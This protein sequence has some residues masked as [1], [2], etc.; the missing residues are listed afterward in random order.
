MPVKLRREITTI[1]DLG[2]FRVGSPVATARTIK[3]PADPE[4]Q[5]AEKIAACKAKDAV[6]RKRLDQFAIYKNMKKAPIF[7]IEKQI[8]ELN[9]SKTVKDRDKKQIMQIVEFHRGYK[10]NPYRQESERLVSRVQKFCLEQGQYEI[11]QRRANAF[12]GRIFAD[13]R[14]YFIENK[15]WFIRIRFH[16]IFCHEKNS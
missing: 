4:V 10:P 9:I 12:G 7:D 6:F 5:R 16:R 2:T 13:H 1:S 14:D 8:S 15:T 11:K 3:P